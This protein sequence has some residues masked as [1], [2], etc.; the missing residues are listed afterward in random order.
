MRRYFKILSRVANST[1]FLAVYCG[2]V[3]YGVLVVAIKITE[4]AS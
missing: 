4:A 3:V 1:I 2:A